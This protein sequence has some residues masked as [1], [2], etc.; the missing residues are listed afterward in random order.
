MIFLNIIA[1][2]LTKIYDIPNIVLYN[3]N[4]IDDNFSNK[5]LI[6]KFFNS[7]PTKKI[8]LEISP[9][10]YKNNKEM[11]ISISEF[12]REVVHFNGQNLYL[13]IVIIYDFE[14][15]NKLEQINFKLLLDKY[16]WFV[17]FIIFCNN[18][19]NLTDILY[20]NFVNIS[21]KKKILNIKYK[22]FYKLEK[23]FN[24]DK[25]FLISS[26]F[27]MNKMLFYNFEIFSFFSIFKIIKNYSIGFLKKKILL[28]NEFYFL[29]L[30]FLKFCKLDN[31]NLSIKF[32]IRFSN[33]SV[34]FNLTKLF[35]GFFLKI[36]KYFNE[37]YI[38]F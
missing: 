20:P 12:L 35:F 2:Y 23:I 36:K 6:K 38:F 4:Q 30:E 10:S 24:L 21:I 34:I 18:Q 11:F 3:H 13:K 1:F 9:E 14:N 26:N 8:M 15:I 33:F 16:S 27:N 7:I 22:I 31:L 19:N 25:I 32:K 28:S 37:E 17:K 29:I 5:I